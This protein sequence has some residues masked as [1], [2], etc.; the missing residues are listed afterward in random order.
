MN[1]ARARY[2]KADADFACQLCIGCGSESS[3][4]FMAH[5]NE[6]EAV[7][8]MPQFIDKFVDAVARHAVNMINVPFLQQFCSYFSC[9]FVCHITSS[10]VFSIPPSISAETFLQRT[11]Q[12]KQPAEAWL[13][14]FF[15]F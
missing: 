13:C 5:L 8:F 11:R 1:G 15:T 14:R 3:G 6:A 12:K 4:F 2:R 10:F 9:G 7:F